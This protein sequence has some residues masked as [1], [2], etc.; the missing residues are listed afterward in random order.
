MSVRALEALAREPAAAKPRASAPV[1][2]AE[3]AAVVDRLRYRLATHIGLIRRERGG[4]I[5]IRF[6]DDDELMRIVDL[7]LSES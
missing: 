7:L 2:D 6:S 4:S 3:T 1:L 5:E